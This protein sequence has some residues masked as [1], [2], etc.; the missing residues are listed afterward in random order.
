MNAMKPTQ[1]LANLAPF[2]V[3]VEELAKSI[4]PDRRRSFRVV[5]DK[6]L[7]VLLDRVGAC[8]L[9]EISLGGGVLQTDRRLRCGNR[10]R[11]RLEY[12]GLHEILDIQANQ[13]SLY[14]L[15]Y[16]HNQH[17][18]LSFRS[19]IVYRDPSIDALNLVYRI[20]RDHWSPL[21]AYS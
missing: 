19:R 20:L 7:Q 6:S 21:D 4:G 5:F 18:R 17:S 1:A 9:K 11:L 13:S 12:Q 10:Y 14:E 2:P 8:H 3:A 15:Y 16:D